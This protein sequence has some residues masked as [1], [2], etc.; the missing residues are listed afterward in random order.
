MRLEQA[1]SSCS[2]NNEVRND[3]VYNSAPLPLLC[4]V[5]FRGPR[6]LPASAPAPR[7]QRSRRRASCCPPSSSSL[8]RSSLL[9]LSLVMTLITTCPPASYRPPGTTPTST[10]CT[11]S[12]SVGQPQMALITPLSAHPVSSGSSYHDAL[13]L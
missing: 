5:S 11:S 9:E 12:S 7:A 1:A 4:S 2:T 13:N 6:H 8:R 3:N 10:R